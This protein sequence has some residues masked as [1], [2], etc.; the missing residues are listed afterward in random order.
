MPTTFL[1]ASQPKGNPFGGPIKH[2]TILPLNCDTTVV[3][4]RNRA[5]GSSALGWAHTIAYVHVVCVEWLAGVRECE[6][7][8]GRG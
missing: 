1:A 4:E 3:L 2:A 8:M 7:N 5:G 6:W